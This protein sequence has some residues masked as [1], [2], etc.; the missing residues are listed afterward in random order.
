[1]PIGVARIRWPRLA[2]QCCPPCWHYHP[3]PRHFCGASSAGGI[4]DAASDTAA[5]VVALRVVAQRILEDAE[6][7]ARLAASPAATE[8]VRESRSLPQVQDGEAVAKVEAPTTQ[9]MKLYFLHN[10][11]PFIGF[12]FCDNAIMILAGDYIDAKLGLAFGITTMAAA[13]LGNTMSDVVGLWI[14][15]FIET[16]ATAMGLPGHGLSLQQM[17]LLSIRILKNTSMIAGIVLGCLLGMFPLIYPEDW[18]FWPSRE[19]MEAAAAEARGVASDVVTQ[20][21]RQVPECE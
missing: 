16:I 4:E 14:S 3:V 12:G 13:G 8:L 11:I 17:E 5:D 21:G 2:R 6:L 19:N 1:M 7:A 15:G 18:R 20:L 10:F 9:Q